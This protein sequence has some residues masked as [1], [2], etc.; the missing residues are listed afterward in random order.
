MVIIESITRSTLNPPPLKELW[1]TGR[2]TEPLLQPTTET[3]PLI[4]S[5]HF[6]FL[7]FLNLFNG[8]IHQLFFIRSFPLIYTQKKREKSKSKSP[9]PNSPVRLK[10]NSIQTGFRVNRL[11]KASDK[12]WNQLF[13]ILG[14]DSLVL[15]LC[16][17]QLS[18]QPRCFPAISR[19]LGAHV[20]V[21]LG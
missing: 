12:P 2:Q 20:V 1:E 8:I 6:I 11:S 9:E 3:H 14:T 18:N 13:C 7:K 16:E 17:I 19:P 21:W 4:D 15:P 5:H 10:K